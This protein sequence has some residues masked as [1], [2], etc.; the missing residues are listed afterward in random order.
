[1]LHL[2]SCYTDDKEQMSN[3]S[4]R[5]PCQLRGFTSYVMSHD[6]AAKVSRVSGH[7]VNIKATVGCL[8]PFWFCSFVV[9]TQRNK[10][11]DHIK[12]KQCSNTR[13]LQCKDHFDLQGLKIVSFLILR[14]TMN[15]FLSFL[16]RI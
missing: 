10:H 11:R 6:E 3:E 15:K 1:M 7:T 9:P 5:T 16:I 14:S 8:L 2:G 12:T 4:L 13:S